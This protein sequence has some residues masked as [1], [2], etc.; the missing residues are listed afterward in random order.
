VSWSPE[1]QYFINDPE[2]EKF[3]HRDY[4]NGYKL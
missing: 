1:E 2:A 4:E 3:F